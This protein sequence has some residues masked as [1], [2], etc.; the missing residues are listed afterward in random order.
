MFEELIIWGPQVADEHETLAQLSEKDRTFLAREL[1]SL[2]DKWEISLNK[3]SCV[4]SYQNDD[5]LLV[6]GL[7]QEVR[8]I[9]RK[10]YYDVRSS[11]WVRG[12]T[13]IPYIHLDFIETP[14]LKQDEYGNFIPDDKKL[15]MGV[16][17]PLPNGSYR[18]EFNYYWLKQYLKFLQTIID[19]NE[20]IV[21]SL[22]DEIPQN[23]PRYKT[24]AE[25]LSM[26]KDIERL[27]LREQADVLRLYANSGVNPEKL[28]E[29]CLTFLNENGE[30]KLIGWSFC[31]ED[32]R[33]FKMPMKKTIYNTSGFADL[34][35]RRVE[36][37]SE[38]VLSSLKMILAHET[39]HVARGHW[40]LR[41]KEPEYSQ[42]RNVMMNCEINADWTA[43]LWMLNELLY[44]TVNGDPQF[45]ILAYKRKDLIYLWAVRILAVYV[46]L[47]WIARN[48]DRVWTEKT[49]TDFKDD[50]KA[51]HPIYQ[52]RLFCTLNHIKEHLDHM[53]EE[54]RKS[55][56]A[57]RTADNTPLDEGLFTQVWNR[58]CDM[59][60]SFEYAFHACWN[61]DERTSLEKLRQGLFIIDKAAPKNNTEVPFF[62][63]YMEEANKELEDYERQWPEI[64][65]KLREYGM[66]FKM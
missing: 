12:H 38:L 33:S 23:P 41:V 51:T 35:E 50:A 6:A 36:L 34:F 2:D 60:F 3:T 26:V 59:I 10:M 25:L 44:D 13:E 66:Y 19:S 4:N 37:V 22:P 56:Y 14:A 32:G 30:R 40:N 45:N 1:K 54:N 20:E 49:I 27:G 24:R 58:A 5:Y 21:I 57:L 65:A 61:S 11:E 63:C 16:K 47:S 17:P 28:A 7:L 46:S 8:S 39:A 64:L 55:D 9:H 48:E 52:F 43:A 18:L 42:E 29:P 15:N 31:G 53:C 62:M